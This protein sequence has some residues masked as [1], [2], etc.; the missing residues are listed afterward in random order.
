VF[1]GSFKGIKYHLKIGI[2]G[3]WVWE[4]QTP[5]KQRLGKILGGRTDAILAAERAI[6]KW[7]RNRRHRDK[8]MGKSTSSEC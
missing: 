3:E 6:E 2:G 8:K 7:D 5:D 1:Q 4:A